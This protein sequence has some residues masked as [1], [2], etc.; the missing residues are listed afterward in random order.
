MFQ[1]AYGLYLR[2]NIPVMED[3]HGKGL[4]IGNQP[5]SERALNEKM[6]C[7]F[8]V[9]N[10]DMHDATG[11]N[12]GSSI[13]S[14][15]KSKTQPNWNTVVLLYNSFSSSCINLL[16]FEQFK[17]DENTLNTYVNEHILSYLSQHYGKAP[18]F[19][20]DTACTFLTHRHF[21]IIGSK[22]S[23]NSDKRRSA[24]LLLA[25]ITNLN[26]GDNYFAKDRTLLRLKRKI[27]RILK[28]KNPNDSVSRKLLEARQ[29]II[30]YRVS[31]NVSIL[32]TLNTTQVLQYVL[33][34][35][36]VV[37]SGLILHKMIN[38]S[39]DV[40][41]RNWS[42]K[43]INERIL[44]KYGIADSLE[45]TIVL[46]KSV[47][48]NPNESWRTAIHNL[49]STTEVIRLLETE[50]RQYPECADLFGTL[51]MAY[52]GA[53][54]FKL[55]GLNVDKAISLR[56]GAIW[57]WYMVKAGVEKKIGHNE[58]L[59][60]YL[61]SCIQALPDTMQSQT[62]HMY[63][64]LRA[65]LNAENW[66]DLGA[67]RPQ[68]AIVDFTRCLAIKGNDPEILYERGLAFMRADSFKNAITDFQ[69]LAA[70]EDF[71]TLKKGQLPGYVYENTARAFYML[72][73]RANV[74]G[75][76]N[77]KEASKKLNEICR[78]YCDSS[79]HYLPNNPRI[80]S[81]RELSNDY[82]KN[83]IPMSDKIYVTTKYSNI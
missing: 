62:K 31:N 24:G 53:D 50:I 33:P 52:F 40:I 23:S 7:H 15:V 35:A 65:T 45:S 11:S 9:A 51:A 34:I 20:F 54:N 60:N 38:Q 74:E 82:D 58:K 75:Y 72:A 43:K 80:K 76:K 55:A 37:I 17:A 6:S 71:R 69:N 26:Q 83:L 13:F 49:S 21:D 32:S 14:W 67:N 30:D 57:D 4:L 70:R 2:D 48:C 77:P 18:G 73:S 12:P 42:V 19:T 25:L 66:L 10:I 68:K 79:E 44:N 78:E 5:F 8:D 61:D 27:N 47:N 22:S 1:F 56:N 29:I 59:Y 3:V 41:D 64:S 81:I 39:D 36:V 28:W 63:Y 46:V 16:E